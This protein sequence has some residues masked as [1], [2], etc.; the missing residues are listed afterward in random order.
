MKKKTQST[1]V[2]GII[3]KQI[4]A[5]GKAY[6]NLE[7]TY[8]TGS[9]KLKE[10]LKALIEKQL[11]LFCKANK[12]DPKVSGSR[13]A[14]R[15]VLVKGLAKASGLSEKNISNRVSETGVLQIRAK[16]A[17]GKTKQVKGSKKTETKKLETNQA[18]KVGKQ[19]VISFKGTQKELSKFMVSLITSPDH[20]EIAKA[21]VSVTETA[22][23]KS[24]VKNIN[25]KK[26]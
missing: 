1:L 26:K 9:E 8:A 4:M 13:Q 18:V 22:S 19:I 14:F 23:F 10:R 6:A 15:T 3:N 11:P 17:G 7:A 24:V 25:S 20:V 5:L 2:S 12:L 21:I 16:G